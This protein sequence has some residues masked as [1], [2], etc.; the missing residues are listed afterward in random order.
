MKI[1]I[2]P[3][4]RKQQPGVAQMNSRKVVLFITLG[5]V[6]ALVILGALYPALSNAGLDWWFHTAIVGVLLGLVGL[7]MIPKS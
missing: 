1:Y 2:K 6:V 4:N 5:W 3:L 7:N